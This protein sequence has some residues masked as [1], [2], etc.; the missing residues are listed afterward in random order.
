MCNL[1]SCGG[2]DLDSSLADLKFLGKVTR[3][4]PVQNIIP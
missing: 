2:L 3:M 4:T 1:I